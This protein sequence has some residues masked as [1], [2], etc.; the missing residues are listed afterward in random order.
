[1]RTAHM[2]VNVKNGEHQHQ[3]VYQYSHIIKA[4]RAN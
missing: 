1:M 3:N 4:D 2:K